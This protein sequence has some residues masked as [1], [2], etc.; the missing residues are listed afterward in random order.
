MPIPLASVEGMNQARTEGLTCGNTVW[1][2]LWWIQVT[3]E[4]IIKEAYMQ[5]TH[6]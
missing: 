5:Y 3:D 1:D 4:A 6:Q 2:V